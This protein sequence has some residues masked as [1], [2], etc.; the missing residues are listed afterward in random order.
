MKSLSPSRKKEFEIRKSSFFL[1]GKYNPFPN[2]TKMTPLKVAKND[3]SSDRDSIK[4][5]SEAGKERVGLY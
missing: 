5:V 1:E 4:P 2:E 3:S